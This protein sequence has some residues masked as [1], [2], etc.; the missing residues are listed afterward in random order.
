MLG[1]VNLK[2]REQSRKIRMNTAFFLKCFF[3]VFIF[4]FTAST[5]AQKNNESPLTKKYPASALQ[6]DA[7]VLMNVILK[8]HPAVGIYQP[9]DYYVKLF[10]DF[11]NSLRDSLTEKQFRYKIKII[12][13][14]LHC[15]HTETLY[16]TKYVRA[17]NKTKP[18]FSPYAFIPVD[19]KLFVLD[20]INRRRDTLLKRGAEITK[21]NGLAIDSILRTCRKLITTDGFNTS[22]KNHYVKMG[23]NSYYPAVFGRPDTFKIEYKNGKEIKTIKYPTIKAKNA[24]SISLAAKDDSLF[25]VCKKAKI[26]YKFL[27]KEKKSMY[28]KIYS[29]SRKKYQKAYRRIFRQLNKNNSENLVIDLRYNGGGSLE[30]SYRLLSYL[31]DSAQTQTLKTGIKKYPYQKYTNGNIWFKLMRFGFSVISEKKTIHDTD[32]YVYTIKP[33]K[34]NHYNKKIYVMINGGSFS[35]SCLVGAYLK[36]N[37]RA[38]FV[39][40]ETSGTIEG[41]NAG[42]TPYYKLPNTKI[43]VRVPAFRIVHDVSPG[44]SGH[45]IIPDY[46]IDYTIKDILMR[47]DLELEKVKVLVNSPITH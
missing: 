22:G 17:H 9:R 15:G 21:I 10:K 1:N 11:K 13:D 5:F 46:K 18:G 36:H 31:L 14:E 42:I 16:S 32:N 3:F 6:Q 12:L 38:T 41:C 27:D 4:C 30:N 20:M 44:I 7:D 45:G 29:F 33:L 34:K 8:M 40:E 23:F 25:T 37:N 19:D 39:G 26:K 47:K 35:A 2:L 24:P 43:K 28:V